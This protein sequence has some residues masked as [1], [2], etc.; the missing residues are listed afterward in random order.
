MRQFIDLVETF[1]AEDLPSP[2]QLVNTK[3]VYELVYS[4]TDF[5]S[6]DGRYFLSRY[7][8]DNDIIDNDDFDDFDGPSG[9]DPTSREFR[10]WLEDWV[11][12]E[13]WDVW[14]NFSHLFDA[15]GNATL[16]RVI[17][18][19]S[20]W[21]PGERHPGV[22][23]SWDADAAEAHWGNYDGQVEWRITA[24]INKS[25]VDWVRTLA[26]NVMPQYKEEREIR[27]FENAPIN[28]VKVERV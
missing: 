28:V 4:H 24:I 15:A 26:M 17:T 23:W 18:A 1:I 20:D 12:D 21:Q 22:Y 13:V 11:D 3:A 2:E 7:A 16:Y 6:L 14:N 25:V 27:I 10:E 9:V 19:P 5:T 8:R